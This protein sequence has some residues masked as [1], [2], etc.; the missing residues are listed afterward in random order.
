[1]RI[2]Q[3]AIIMLIAGFAAL[4]FGL[5]G[6]ASAD[7]PKASVDLPPGKPG[8]TREVVVAGGCFW[9]TEGAFQQ[10]KG[11]TAVVSGYSGGTKETADYET[12]CSGRTNHAEAIKITYDPSQITLGEILASS[13]PCTIRRPRIAKV[14]MSAGNIVRPSSLRTMMKSASPRRTSS[15]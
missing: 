7:L 14:R 4:G 6:H 11:V 12:V 9:C 10:L 5:R 3:G 1:M 2:R 8:E 15:N 13:S